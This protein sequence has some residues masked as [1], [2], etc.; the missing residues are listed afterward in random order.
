MRIQIRLIILLR[1]RIP[2]LFD[3]DPD[4]GYKNDADPDADPDPQHWHEL[5][6]LA[7]GETLLWGGAGSPSGRSD[8]F[9]LVVSHAPIS[10]WSAKR[11]FCNRGKKVWLIESLEKLSKVNRNELTQKIKTRNIFLLYCT[12]EKKTKNLTDAYYIHTQGYSC[13]IKKRICLLFLGVSDP[14]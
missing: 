11:G 10:P 6:F 9:R 12:A 8:I 13:I 14:A 4:P 2:I 1:R 3:A 7:G 5:T